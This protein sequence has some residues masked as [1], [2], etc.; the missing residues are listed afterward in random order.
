[1]KIGNWKIDCTFSSTP[2]RLCYI[3][4]IGYIRGI[5]AAAATAAAAA[6]GVKEERRF[7]CFRLADYPQP[8]PGVKKN[9]EVDTAS[10]NQI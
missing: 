9:F 3:A 5:R 7:N 4:L 10:L 8:Q 2:L 6:V 1:M